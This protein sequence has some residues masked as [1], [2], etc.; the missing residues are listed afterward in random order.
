MHELNKT[1]GPTPEVLSLLALIVQKYKY[2]QK[3]DNATLLVQKYKCWHKLANTCA[4][5]DSATLL[6]QKY[7]STNADTN[8]PTPVRRPI[9]L[10]R[11]EL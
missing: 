8:S 5:S 6:V 7:K 10:L 4:P 3:I 1:R 9:A 11:F 2:W